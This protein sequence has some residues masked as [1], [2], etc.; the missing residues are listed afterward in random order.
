M[1]VEFVDLHAFQS[2]AVGK[3]ALGVDEEL[4]VPN[5]ETGAQ[6]LGQ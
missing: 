1:V 3:D 2:P 6:L 4:S 5:P